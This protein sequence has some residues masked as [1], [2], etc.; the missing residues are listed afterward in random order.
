[1]PPCYPHAAVIPTKVGIRTGSP[2]SSASA[3]IA[4]GRWKSRNSNR[5]F[6]TRARYPGKSCKS[7]DR[8]TCHLLGNRGDPCQDFVH[9]E[10][11]DGLAGRLSFPGGHVERSQLIDLNY[12]GYP[13]AGTL[14]AD[15]EAPHPRCVSHRRDGTDKGNATLIKAS[16]RDDYDTMRPSLLAACRRSQVAMPDVA[17]FHYSNSRP[18]GGAS[19]HARSSSE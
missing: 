14:K 18:T 4:R 2:T 6:N 15:S 10:V 16:R 12:S 19:S 9:Y 8:T 7:L 1:M 5:A 3:P 13:R 17:S 11:R